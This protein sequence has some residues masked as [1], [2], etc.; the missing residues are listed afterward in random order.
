VDDA[1]ERTA[2]PDP[3]TEH[4]HRVVVGVDGSDGSRAAL[5]WAMAAAAR[6]G[7]VLEVVSAF[8]MESYWVDPLLM[9]PEWV[10]A[11]RSDTEER[12]RNLVEAVRRDPVVAAVPGAVLVPVEVVVVAGAPAEHLVRIAEGAA[13]LVVGSRGR[14]GIRS[15]VLG[16]VALH[17]STHARCP[18]VVVHPHAAPAGKVVVGLDD[19]DT[20]RWALRAAV[21]AAAELDIDDVEAVV[22]FKL[23]EYWSELRVTV[24]PSV[25]E[26]RAAALHRAQQ[27]VADTLGGH[28]RVPVRVVVVEGPADEALI[29]RSADAALLVVGSRSRSQLPGMLLGSVALHC[30]VHASCPVM[31]VHPDRTGRPTGAPP[32][33]ASVRG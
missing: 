9:N 2:R 12:V 16:S 31:V 6:R 3:A 5:V 21:D 29:Q 32:A 15:T 14:G 8:S 25:D 23:P 13:V 19:S 17:C 18:V 1:T 26:A 7:A 27:A 33:L 11:V 24:V 28:P 30:V 22:A 20:G 4:P 10:D